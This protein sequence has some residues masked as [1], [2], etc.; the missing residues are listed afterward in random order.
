MYIDIKTKPLTNRKQK[1]RP[2]SSYRM[3]QASEEYLQRKH[4]VL[5]LWQPRLEFLKEKSKT[6]N[7]YSNMY[8]RQC[9]G[10]L[11][12]TLGMGRSVV[13]ERGGGVI[14]RNAEITKA[15]AFRQCSYPSEHH[16][17]PHYPTTPNPR[18]KRGLWSRCRWGMDY[19]HF[20]KRENYI[21]WI[22][23]TL[24]FS[25]SFSCT[26]KVTCSPIASYGLHLSSN[27]LCLKYHISI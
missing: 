22:L 24:L 7:A 23:T 19:K 15:C 12:I 2:T 13:S 8:L 21:I 16:T 26:C 6:I 25:K 14:K 3:M 17:P 1:V 10:N 5:H 4:P 27:I 11:M 9:L 20:I 18:E